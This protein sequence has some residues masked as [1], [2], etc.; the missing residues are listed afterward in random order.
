MEDVLFKEIIMDHVTKKV[1]RL[2]SADEL[3]MYWK[4][5][6]VGTGLLGADRLIKRRFSL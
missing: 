2:N 5:L 6:S 1:R 3:K 4:A